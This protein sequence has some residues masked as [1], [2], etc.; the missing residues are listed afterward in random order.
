MCSLR[1][2]AVT[3]LRGYPHL[4][5]R[6]LPPEELV[7]EGA[8]RRPEAR[9]QEDA[10]VGDGLQGSR[11]LVGETEPDEELREEEEEEED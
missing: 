5:G 2:V 8:V 4:S 9:L 6:G 7:V 11:A 10:A 3:R 1:A